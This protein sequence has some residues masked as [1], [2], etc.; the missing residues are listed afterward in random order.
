MMIYSLFNGISQVG[1]T[2][3]YKHVDKF[4]FLGCLY[5]VIYGINTYFVKKRWGIST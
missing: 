2:K 1:M 5:Q 3:N 4:E